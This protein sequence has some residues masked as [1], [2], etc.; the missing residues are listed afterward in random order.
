M[1]AQ[2]DGACG[3]RSIAGTAGNGNSAMTKRVSLDRLRDISKQRSIR[4]PVHV[5]IDRMEDR[6]ELPTAK[7]EWPIPS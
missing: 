4:R 1:F 7:V 2:L 6:D 3:A 5:K